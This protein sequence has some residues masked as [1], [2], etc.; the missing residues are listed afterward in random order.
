MKD[1]DEESK[2]IV[3]KDEKQEFKMVNKAENRVYVWRKRNCWMIALN[4]A[5]HAY[6][7]KFL[8]QT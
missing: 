5:G 3:G 8:A 1:Q 2:M 4:H 7:L 6:N